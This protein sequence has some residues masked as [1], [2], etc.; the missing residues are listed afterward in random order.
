MFPTLR[1]ALAGFV[2]FLAGI[3]VGAALLRDVQPRSFLAVADC[4]NHCYRPSDLAGL[5]AAAGLRHAPGWIPNK[6]KETDRCVAITNPFP[7]ARH[8]FVLFPKRDIRNIGE[9]AAADQPYLLDCIGV[10]QALIA[11]YHL[12]DYQLMSNGPGLQRIAYLHL[13]L[14]GE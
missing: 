14:M 4:R 1:I 7:E 3:A 13:H 5:F 6:V 12:T 2:V 9:L 11:E 8:H 10:M